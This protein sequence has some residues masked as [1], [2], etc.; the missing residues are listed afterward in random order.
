MGVIMTTNKVL[1]IFRTNKIDLI[2]A[3][4]VLTVENLD[5]EAIKETYIP[6]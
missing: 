3:H 2:T 6:A 4:C 5:G 1:K